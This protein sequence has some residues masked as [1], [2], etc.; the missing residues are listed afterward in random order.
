MTFFLDSH[1]CAKNQIDSEVLINFLQE[2]GHI[3]TD[4]VEKAD[5]IIVNSC[6]FIE[7]AKKES[8]EAVFSL[9]KDFPKAKIILAG[10][11]AQRYAKDLKDS[12]KEVDAIFGN[13][14]L[15]KIKEVVKQL[16]ENKRPV[17]V[18]EQGGVCC[19]KRP[20]KLQFKNQCYVKIAEGCDNHCSFCAIPLIRGEL[21]SRDIADIVQEIKELLA[22]GMFEVNLIAQDLAAYGKGKKD[23]GQTLAQLLKEITK[24]SGN[25]WL[26][27]LYI[28]PDHFPLD[29]LPVIKNDKRILP[30][31]DIPFQSG[32]DD[33]IKKMNRR[34]T[35][36]EYIDLVKKIRQE[37]EDI[38]LR[39]TFMTGFPGE[40]QGDILQTLDFMQQIKSD[41]SGTFV[42][43]KE[44]GTPAFCFG[45]QVS[46]K[47]AKKRCQMI[48]EEQQ[49]ISF[50]ALK[51]R[52]NK[53]ID[54]LIEEVIQTRDDK[55]LAIGRAWFCAPDVDGNIVVEYDKDDISSNKNTKDIKEGAVVK[56]HTCGVSGVDIYG[57]L[58]E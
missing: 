58:C 52:C 27:L 40:T 41:W 8:L 43:S 21:R 13:R 37:L 25:F 22:Q 1:G 44:E 6:G 32:A 10:C 12:L 50:L 15:S 55:G 31:F 2:Q 23:K 5:I 48:Q 39:T 29:I 46:K 38:A 17:I 51:N 47:I 49:K 24:L 16:Q 7:S 42:Y 18:P 3:Y 20:I 54:V 19:S 26:R 11:L 28:H 45:G 34:G 33:I 57:V 9:K 53:D 4:K 14:D 56:V 35:K 30:Y 36:Q